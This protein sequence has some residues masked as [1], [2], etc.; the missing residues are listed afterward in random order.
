MAADEHPIWDNYITW[1]SESLEG[2]DTP[3]THTPWEST[4]YWSDTNERHLV[5]HNVNE[6]HDTDLL[7]VHQAHGLPAW[8]TTEPRPEVDSE[9]SRSDGERRLVL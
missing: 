8:H 5:E 9:R 1:H 2:I 7:V 4:T 6:T 3:D